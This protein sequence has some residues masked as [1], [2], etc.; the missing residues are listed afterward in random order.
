M[1]RLLFGLILLVILS[2]IPQV[3]EHFKEEKQGFDAACEKATK[4]YGT[5]SNIYNKT[6]EEAVIVQGSLNRT[7]EE[8]NQED[9]YTKQ[10]G[11]EASKFYI[12]IK[13][14]VAEIG[15]TVKTSVS[16]GEAPIGT[17]SQ[18]TAHSQ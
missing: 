15:D 1:R 12:I 8:L 4:A 16:E 13:S 18:L 17:S 7:K 11:P 3:S 9:D 5:A 6:K 2:Q 10:T 14:L